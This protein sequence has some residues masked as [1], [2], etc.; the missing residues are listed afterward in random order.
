M[1][2][3]ARNESNEQLGTPEHLDRVLY[4]TTAKGW[5]ALFMVML[6]MGA[7]VA[8]AALGEVS[9]YVQAQGIILSRGG[10]VF[11]ATSSGDGTL[12]RIIPTAGDMVEK[13]QVVA[14]ISDAEVLERYASALGA[15]EERL[16]VLRDREAEVREENRLAARSLARERARLKQIE[17]TGRDLVKTA[18]KRL[19]G[20]RRLFEKG[21]VAR[22]AVEDAEAALDV[23][24]RNLFEVMRRYD[25]LNAD[26]RRRQN[27]LK[28]ALVEVRS[29]YTRAERHVKEVAAVIET[30]RIRAP[31]SGRMT[32]SKAQVGATLEPGDRVLSI[33]TGGD[34]LDVLIYVSPADGKRVKAGMRA[35]VTPATVR[36]E[37]FGS[38]LGKVESLSKFPVSLDGII[39]A[40]QNQD[41]ARTFSQAGP[42]YPGRVALARDSSTASGFAWTS[43]H[44]AAV[45]ITPG[46][47]ARVEIE[48]S[49]QRPAALVV[50]WVRERLN[51]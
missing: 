36:R 32:E 50:P 48:V 10:M 31:V 25:D 49:R 35:L 9:T 14:E 40:L 42:P 1:S 20:H 12:T 3:P 51:L 29:E 21:L 16:Q 38:I 26:D 33:E 23:A 44:A 39:A 30:W 19:K 37:E 27:D 28:A 11:D 17:G 43:P 41:L 24:R 8:W 45:N 7:V 6:M 22:M 4:V 2:K 15:A 34:G 46:T 47:L 18:N 5:L 13:G